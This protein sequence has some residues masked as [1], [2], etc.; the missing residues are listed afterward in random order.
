MTHANN[1]PLVYF[2]GLKK[3]DQ[4]ALIKFIK[5]YIA[6]TN[7]YRQ[8]AHSYFLYIGTPCKGV[9][10]ELKHMAFYTEI[11]KEFEGY[12]PVKELNRETEAI[13]ARSKET[14]VPINLYYKKLKSIFARMQV[15]F[16]ELEKKEIADLPLQK[17]RQ[18]L[19]KL[20]ELNYEFWNN[21]FLPDKFDPKGDEFIQEHLK[22]HKITM[23]REDIDA[24]IKPCFRNF[25]E[26]SD[27]TLLK[28]AK[29]SNGKPS[30]HNNNNH[31][32]L[33]MEGINKYLKHFYYVQNS[34]VLVKF[35]TEKDILP[36]IDE[37]KVLSSDELDK[38][39]EYLELLS[40]NR[41]KKHQELV[42][43]YHL[44]HES[45]NLFYLYQMLTL[46]RD[47]RKEYVLRLNHFFELFARRIARETKIDL[48]LLHYATSAEL[49]EENLF[50][51][52]PE[53]EQRKKGILITSN[54][55]N[56][57]IIISGKKAAEL[58]TLLHNQLTDSFNEIKGM[59]ACKGKAR[60]KVKIILGETHF[61]KFEEGDILVAV[62]TRPE[63]V[64]LMKK[65]AAIVTDEGGLTCHA[66][67]IAREL[68]VP[69][70]IGTQIATKKLMDHMNVEVNA[71]KGTVKL[72]N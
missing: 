40:A 31:Q 53:L 41:K 5:H 58:I 34:W 44:S 43:K 69:C 36:I 3:E 32:N 9:L 49:A 65:A 39:I 42:Q 64:P 29:L 68:K 35:L 15:L 66:A 70:I 54:K 46:M 67:V 11:G 16:S 17:I 56:K 14:Q 28:I 18:Y 47:E 45:T 60:G 13:I 27:L 2:E 6:T 30:S 50:E 23:L 10:D 51:L 37:M 52:L 72:I 62:M 57:D 71:D 59:V 48:E 22:L 25:M 19:L 1:L 7:F 38:R 24:L 4:Q 55:L 21:G 20:D 8:G 63:Y 26:A 61:T 33:I 12:Y